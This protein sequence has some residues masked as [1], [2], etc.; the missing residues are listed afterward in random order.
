MAFD[1]GQRVISKFYGVGTITS[2]FFKDAEDDAKYPV[3][4]QR[5]KF[6]KSGIETH[7][8]V[9]KLEPYE[10]SKPKA[11]RIKRAIKPKAMRLTKAQVALR[12]DPEVL[13]LIWQEYLRGG[14][15][16]IS[17][18]AAGVERLARKLSNITSLSEIDAVDYISPAT[19]KTHAMKF[20]VMLPVGADDIFYKRVS[21]FFGSRTTKAS[22]KEV[23][24][25]SRALSEWLM[26]EHGALPEKRVGV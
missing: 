24:Y 25:N 7:V 11:T 21:A 19:E 17:C 9:A 13:D 12:D 3:T 4:Y 8:Q 20:Y 5:V 15:I 16:L 18:Q 2:E 26:K 1:I 10:D 14:R 23:Q 6:D 22:T